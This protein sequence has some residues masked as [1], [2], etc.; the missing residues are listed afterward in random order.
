[1][2]ILIEYEYFL[3]TKIINNE[4]IHTINFSLYESIILED[5]YNIICTC[6]HT[7]FKNCAGI[8]VCILGIFLDVC[9][10]A[11]VCYNV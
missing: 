11:Y 4:Y 7:Y 5:A 3:I 2:D 1:M 9:T 8:L 6:I 10:C